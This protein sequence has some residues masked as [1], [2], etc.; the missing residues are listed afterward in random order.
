MSLARA[1]ISAALNAD[2]TQNE[3]KAFLV[4]FQQTLGYG[5]AS[6]AL[7]FKRI[8][9]LARVRIDRLTPALRAIADQGLIEVQPHPIYGQS[10]SIPA[11]LLA[12][13]PQRVF[14]PALPQNRNP[15]PLKRQPPPENQ[16]HTVNNPTVNH[17]TPLNAES[18]PYPA[19]FDAASRR[20]ASEILDGLSPHDANDCLHILQHALQQ[21]KVKSPLGLLY[22]LAKAARHGTLDRSG[23]TP[24]TTPPTTQTAANSPA[25]PTR[26]RLQSIQADIQHIQN[27]YKL[28]GCELPDIEQRK[29]ASLREEW[30]RLRQ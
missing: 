14:T 28:A 26:W 1:W 21:G 10:F 20:R 6:D 3:L 11:P 2:L 18:L 23:L 27:L 7:T 29:L 5:K 24:T 17:P 12:Q 19:S 25:A 9:K 13:Y 22:Q 16:V 15:T 30:E 4:I 8:A